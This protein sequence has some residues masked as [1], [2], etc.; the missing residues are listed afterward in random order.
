MCGRLIF[1][2]IRSKKRL[3]TQLASYLK[4]NVTSDCTS[5]AIK[6]D[7]TKNVAY[8]PNPAAVD[9]RKNVAYESN[10]MA[11]NTKKNVSYAVHTPSK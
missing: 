1:F 3:Q 5:R 11:V 9:T 7:T 6:V 4:Y 8:K 2:L 10:S